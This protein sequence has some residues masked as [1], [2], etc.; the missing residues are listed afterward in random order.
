ME[1]RQ[2][3]RQVLPLLNLLAPSLFPENDRFHFKEE[4]RT[5]WSDGIERRDGKPLRSL[6]LL[7]IFLSDAGLRKSDVTVCP[8]REGL[9][10]LISFDF[11]L[12]SETSS[13]I[14]AKHGE[15]GF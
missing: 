1:L 4:P 7:D 10:D 11:E 3:P 9:S 13:E 8:R 6:L 5:E 12:E 14:L 15:S 2:T